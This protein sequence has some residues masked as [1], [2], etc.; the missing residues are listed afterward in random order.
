MAKKSNNSSD[1]RLRG[2]AQTVAQT[3]SKLPKYTELRGSVYWFKRRAP[4]PLS[5]RDTLDL[6]G[7][8]IS[9]GKNG[10]VKFSLRTSDAREASR[11]ARKYAHLLDEA[12]EGAGH[13]R[14]APQAHARRPQSS[15]TQ[16]TLVEASELTSAQ[17]QRAAASMY[18]DLLAADE[19]TYFEGL[20][21]LASEDAFASMDDEPEIREPDRYLW[22]AS[23]LPP[24]GLR[25]Q[26]QLLK[27]IMPTLNFY[28]AQVA[29]KVVAGPAPELIPFADAFRRF[30]D[31]MEKRR[32]AQHVPTPESEQG[33]EPLTLSVLYEKFRTYKTQTGSWKNPE[34]QDAREYGPVVREFIKVVGDKEAHRLNFKDG[35]KYFEYMM[36]RED[37]SLGTKKRNFSRVKAL[38]NYGGKKHSIPNITGPLEINASYKKTHNSYE[39]FTADDLKALFH[40]AAYEKGTFKKASEYWLPILGLYTGARI[41][42]L[43]SLRV[44]HVREIDG[45]WCYFV[46]SI[47][48]NKGGK[49]QY[50]PRWIPLHPQVLKA[51]FLEHWKTVANE[52][53]ER[54]F[55]E[56]GEAQRDGP[57]KR[58]TTDFVNYRRSVGVGT[59]D[60]RSTKV[61]HSFRSTLVSE[62][63]RRKTDDYTRIQL[64]G[65]TVGD[66]D[67]KFKGVH[68]DVYD[69]SEFDAKKSL[70]VLAKA[71][72]GLTHPKFVDTTA[73]ET[74]RLRRQQKTTQQ[75]MRDATPQH[76][77]PS[78][79]RAA[80]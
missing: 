77:K 46:S 35:E 59:T 56:L 55:P 42:E 69:Q 21:A 3:E 57:A 71:D 58:A 19:Q 52:G 15:R 73:M 18:A 65:H 4:K 14:E 62:L 49:N 51:G 29:H 24:V 61:F 34:V 33:R 74:A 6:D 47:K 12:A 75:S 16:P 23:D 25:G 37:I 10:Y 17:I 63:I 7:Q 67:S 45:V 43:A 78:R 2:V 54:I 44:D 8:P 60:G 80:T 66:G 53:H 30:V 48:A 76:R 72:F 31:A 9:I 79:G 32:Q 50:A 36:G 13:A 70:K 39:R 68:F 22:S 26:A 11:L 28:L 5:P 64:L 1:S 38:L 41:D 20:A 40:S 27:Q